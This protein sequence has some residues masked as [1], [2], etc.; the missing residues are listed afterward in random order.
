MKLLDEI[1]AKSL[2]PPPR[3]KVSEFAERERRLSSETSAATGRW[4]N[5][6]YQIEMQD[7]FNDPKVKTAIFMTSTQ[8]GKTEIL[9]N[10]IAYSIVYCPGSTTFMLP[11]ESLARDYSKTQIGPLCRDTPALSKVKTSRKDGNTHLVKTWPGGSLRMVG[12]Q[13]ADKLSSF[14]APR[15]LIDELDRCTKIVRN[16]AGIVEGS[17][18]DLLLE[19]SKNWGSSRFALFTSTPTVETVS[20]IEIWY[21]KS[22][23][24]IPLVPCIHC[25]FYQFL[26]WE[27]FTWQGKG[28]ANANPIISSIG[29]ECKNCN[30]LFDEKTRN[31]WLPELKWYKQKPE[32]LDIAGFHLNA[33]Y[34]PWTRW[35]ELLVK[36]VDAANNQTKRMVFWNTTLGLPFSLDAVKAP[37]WVALYERKHTYKRY[38]IPA[39]ARVLLAAVDVQFD[40][41]EVSIIAF[42]RS[43]SF[44][45]THEVILGNTSSTDSEVWGE[46]DELLG[47]DWPREDGMKM[48]VYRAAID[49]HFHTNTVAQYARD[50]KRIIP[51][52]GVDNWKN[53]LLSARPLEIKRN[54]KPF[55][56]GKRRWP[57]GVSLFKLDLYNRLKLQPNP[58]GSFPA[59]YVHFCQS[60]GE[61]YFKQITGEV[62]K[63]EQD[64][65]GKPK[66]VWE[67][68]HEAVE[69]L[70]CFVY[71]LALVKICGI[72]LWSD[73]RWSKPI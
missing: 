9:K 67:K 66:M 40:R 44:V 23:Q 35:E 52:T 41:L 34:S 3:I 4:K 19:R 17:P 1:I 46:L 22:D 58:D 12:S 38:T 37:D 45:I 65:R 62:C 39:L 13:T 42:F 10:I 33:F 15:L 48:Q 2:T 31:K 63:L 30:K 69:A 70:D 60:L 7:V 57:I 5:I 26:A 73:E 72:H 25:G 64:A 43:Q 36:Y 49:A 21:Q 61:E 68:Q 11:S 14:P 32:I 24:R 50:R 16:S 54:G 29:F 28:D 47:R 55:R 53:E 6:P 20:P 56:T 27:Q 59:E 71:C 18:I 8:I 51:I